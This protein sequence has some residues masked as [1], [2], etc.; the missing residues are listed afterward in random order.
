MP[1]A[2]ESDYLR[3]FLAAVDMRSELANIRGNSVCHLFD[4]NGEIHLNIQF[5]LVK[6]LD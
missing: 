5:S 1:T 2:V 4:T 3:R 6:S